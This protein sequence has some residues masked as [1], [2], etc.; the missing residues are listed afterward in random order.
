M[1]EEEAQ[2]AEEDEGDAMMQPSRFWGRRL[3]HDFA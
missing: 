1:A 2:V 3:T